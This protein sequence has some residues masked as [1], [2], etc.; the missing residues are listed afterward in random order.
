M[1][2]RGAKKKAKV[3]PRARTSPEA[4]DAVNSA[5]PSPEAGRTCPPVLHSRQPGPGLGA[6]TPPAAGPQH[7][8]NTPPP[9][10]PPSSRRR[11]RRRRRRMEGA[12]PGSSHGGGQG[13][14]APAEHEAA[15]GGHRD[16]TARF[17]RAREAG[18]SSGSVPA[19]GPWPETALE[20]AAAEL[21]AHGAGCR[22]ALDQLADVTGRLVR[23]RANARRCV[24]CPARVARVGGR[25]D[26]IWEP[27]QARSTDQ[28]VCSQSVPRTGSTRGTHALRARRWPPPTRS[29]A[30]QTPCTA[31]WPPSTPAATACA[32]A[33]HLLLSGGGGALAPCDGAALL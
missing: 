31:R 2:A 26:P 24:A 12:S 25:R 30:R 9:P 18:T 29:L 20:A 1:G 13:P 32:A 14:G 10:P 8:A 22:R 3:C 19:R 23:E 33:P 15:A 6:R 11:R 17:R 28:A 16:L 21:A 4:P 5:T 7:P 27:H